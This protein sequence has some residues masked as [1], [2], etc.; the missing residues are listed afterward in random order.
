MNNSNDPFMDNYTLYKYNIK[1]SLTYNRGA[2]NI[3]NLKKVCFKHTTDLTAPQANISNFIGFKKPEVNRPETTAV[4][5][6]IDVILLN[7][8]ILVD[9]E[10]MLF[11]FKNYIELFKNDP[12]L[13]IFIQPTHSID[14]LTQE[15]FKSYYYTNLTPSEFTTRTNK[16]IK[17]FPIKKIQTNILYYYDIDY[18]IDNKLNC[19]YYSLINNKIKINIETV[20]YIQFNEDYIVWF[21]NK[22]YNNKLHLYY[23]ATIILITKPILI[24]DNTSYIYLTTVHKKYIQLFYNWFNKTDRYT[25][26]LEQFTVY[27]FSYYFIK[28]EKSVRILYDFYYEY[29]G[30]SL[31]PTVNFMSLYT[32]ALFIGAVIQFNTSLYYSFNNII[33]KTLEHTIKI[34]TTQNSGVEYIQKTNYVCIIDNLPSSI[35]DNENLLLNNSY[36]HLDLENLH[37]IIAIIKQ[38]PYFNILFFTELK[39]YRQ[40]YKIITKLPANNIKLYN[41]N[42]KLILRQIINSIDSHEYRTLQLSEYVFDYNTE[43]L[44]ELIHPT[45][46]KQYTNEINNIL[47][48]H[49]KF[50]IISYLTKNNTINQ[51]FINYYKKYNICLINIFDITVDLHYNKYTV[52]IVN[53]CY[54]ITK[55]PHY[56]YIHPNQYFNDI[57][58]YMIT[59]YNKYMV[60][61]IKLLDELLEKNPR[62]KKLHTKNKSSTACIVSNEK[63]KYKTNSVFEYSIS[64]NIIE[65]HTIAQLFTLT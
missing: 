46:V 11:N 48:V 53:K 45:T 2:F 37:N 61:T 43:H 57:D 38:Y 35:I 60:S 21:L 10:Y 1:T 8:I 7:V 63:F 29:D 27:I 55:Q 34:N 62:D 17:N 47:Q 42:N 20:D 26:T 5:K 13:N 58:R 16:F 64:Y 54:T 59:K 33:K 3:Y 44:A 15:L 52:L 9:S 19:F 25:I 31:I 23:N 36:I 30:G 40:F 39:A 51:T 24:T 41:S 32:H 6:Y 49:S 50:I 65:T 22:I 4:V 18:N 12:T 56:L 28:L 14:V